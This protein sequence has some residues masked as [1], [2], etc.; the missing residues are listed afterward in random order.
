MH[1][2]NGFVPAAS[3]S[4]ASI[5]STRPEFGLF[6]ALVR[7]AGVS[8]YLEF[9][10]PKTVFVPKNDSFPAG[11]L[12][13][14][15]APR[16]RQALQK[17]VLLHITQPAEYRSSLSLRTVVATAARVYLRVQTSN[18]TVY[19]TRNRIP[20]TEPDIQ[21]TNG[22]VHGLSR[23][24]FGEVDY[25]RVCPPAIAITPTSAPATVPPT[26]PVAGAMEALVQNLGIQFPSAPG[27]NAATV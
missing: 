25:K 19:L 20:I 1:V 24:I 4:I 9:M 7:A 6:N 5:L 12:E 13:C 23:V 26:G 10:S 2:I 22:V 17:I 11:A 21:A 16:N 14:L 18:G 3:G 15:K 27:P 8:Y